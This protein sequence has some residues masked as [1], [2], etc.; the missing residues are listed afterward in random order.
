[1]ADR[2]HRRQLA[3]AEE[4]DDQ[5]ALSRTI[6]LK[7]FLLGFDATRARA[8][9]ATAATADEYLE[10][11]EIEDPD[12]PRT[13][14]RKAFYA[15]LAATCRPGD[16]EAERRAG[17]LGRGFS[18]FFG[19]S[20]LFAWMRI[21]REVRAATGTPAGRL[22]TGRTRASA[23]RLRGVA[24]SASHLEPASLAALDYYLRYATLDDLA[25]H[26]GIL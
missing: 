24:R 19:Y 12:A 20:P 3:A 9:A 7:A 26:H 18:R 5:L 2:F 25:R 14:V 22:G 16:R 17:E 15:L 1:M 6:A 21:V 8:H 13:I 10:L 4:I 11:L 23:E